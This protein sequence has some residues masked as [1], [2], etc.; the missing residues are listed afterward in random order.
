[1]MRFQKSSLQSHVSFGLL[2]FL[3]FS[4]LI[5]WDDVS[6]FFFFAVS[7]PL[8]L[9]YI[10]KQGVPKEF[11]SLQVKV[12]IAIVCYLSLRSFFSDSPFGESFRRFRWGVEILLFLLCFVLAFREWMS[13]ARF[14]GALFAVMAGLAAISVIGKLLIAG[15]MPDR[16]FGFGF[17]DHPIRGS[18]TLLIIWSF[19]AV[20]LLTSYRLPP[21]P[22]H[23]GIL[24]VSGLFVL[25]FVFLSKSRGP[26]LSGVLVFLFYLSFILVQ[27][28]INKKR[29][30]VA[31]SFLISLVVTLLLLGLDEWIYE[32]VTERG[33]S[34]RLGIW[35]AV[36]ASLPE[37][38]LFGVG[39]VVQ[40]VD[41]AP[42]SELRQKY[43]ISFEHTHNLFLQTWLHGGILAFC[44]LLFLLGLLAQKICFS[45]VQ[46][47]RERLVVITLLGLTVLLNLTDTVRLLSSPTPDWVIFWM[48]VFFCSMYVWPHTEVT[49]QGARP[50]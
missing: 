2:A 1:M 25:A 44:L 30:V 38:W 37:Y 27:S 34:Y 33:D 41:T 17:L 12:I 5:P 22:I 49:Q 3:F 32:V 43:G 13:K 28:R 36:V 11:E 6:R 50:Q 26:M 16:I 4:L 24:L 18:S 35:A 9:V 7:A 31:C 48:P 10:Y 46:G 47:V 39:E 21:R 45:Q 40:F 19:G 42:G 14:Y 29:A 20:M 15:E 8:S 23:Y